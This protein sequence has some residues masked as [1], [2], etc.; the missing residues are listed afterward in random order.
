M[1]A[2]DPSTVNKIFRDLMNYDWVK[3][4]RD[5]Y[6]QFEKRMLNSFENHHLETENIPAYLGIITDFANNA[7]KYSKFARFP[8]HVAVFHIKYKYDVIEFA[9]IQKFLDLMANLDIKDKGT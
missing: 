4:D 9:T 3:I 1:E 7:Q 6:L 5:V 8:L 2:M